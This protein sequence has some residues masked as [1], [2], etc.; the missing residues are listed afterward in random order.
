MRINELSPSLVW[1]TLRLDGVA[2]CSDGRRCVQEGGAAGELCTGERSCTGAAARFSGS[3]ESTSETDGDCTVTTGG[4]GNDDIGDAALVVGVMRTMVDEVSVNSLV[5]GNSA[6]TGAAGTGCFWDTGTGLGAVCARGDIG[7]SEYAS[8]DAFIETR[9]CVEAGE[10]FR[11]VGIEAAA[12]VE[13][14][15]D[16][17]G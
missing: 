5:L 3:V 8:D 10:A 1:D 15:R 9:P 11:D 13:G 2:C 6:G 14:A 17:S 12:D 16:G 7:R 4:T